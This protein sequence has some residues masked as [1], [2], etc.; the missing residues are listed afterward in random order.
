MVRIRGLKEKEF[1][2][3]MKLIQKIFPDRANSNLFLEL[4]EIF[5]EGF[6]V[7]EE[8]GRIVGFAIGII[9]EREKGRILLIGVDEGHRGKGIGTQ[10]LRRLVLI[11]A[12]NG[13]LRIELEVRISNTKAIRF[14]QRN[15]FIKVKRV[16]NFY[17]D[18][19]DG[20]VMMKRL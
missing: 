14:Y 3:L 6:V 8:G 13:A 15:G 10:L 12:T 4:Y 5:P 9:S 1:I 16:R 20:Y 11:L 19:E 2:D 17:E 18:G 7:A